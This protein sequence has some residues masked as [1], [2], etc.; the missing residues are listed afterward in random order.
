[1]AEENIRTLSRS[2]RVMATYTVNPK[3]NTYPNLYEAVT[4]GCLQRIADS[5]EK[6]EVPYDKLKDR[7]NL[8]G[9]KYDFEIDRN[10]KLQ[11]QL[12]VEKHKVTVLSTKVLELGGVIPE[13]GHRGRKKKNG[14]T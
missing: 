7:I 13:W 8:L 9:G 2:T 4:A 1:M 6:L 5:L 11:N 14:T 10:Q 3:S 12:D